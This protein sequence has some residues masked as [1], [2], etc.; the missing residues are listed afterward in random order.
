MQR[1]V[2]KELTH[3]VGA[4]LTTL[5]EQYSLLV[6]ILRDGW[7]GPGEKYYG[8]N[9]WYG[10]QMEK[11]PSSNEFVEISNMGCFCDIPAVDFAIHMTKYSRFGLAF[12]KPT[13]ISKGVRP[14]YY[15][16]RD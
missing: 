16:P 15:V 5:D 4:R 8:G 7:L 9:V 14:I 11:S 6:K 3:F 1:Y 2:S 13:L 10:P 12:Y